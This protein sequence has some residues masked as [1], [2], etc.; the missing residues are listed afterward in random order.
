MRTGSLF[1]VAAVVLT[2]GASEAQ[3]SY[4]TQQLLDIAETSGVCGEGGVATAVLSADGK[5]IDAT[6]NSAPVVAFAPVA[7]G[8]AG[9]VG[10]LVLGASGGDGPNGTGST[11]STSGT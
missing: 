5:N 9:L 10:V 6:C 11:G 4:T 2:A 8:L 7:G 3:T 1:I